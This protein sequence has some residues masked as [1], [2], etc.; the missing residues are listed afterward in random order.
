MVSMGKESKI[1][2]LEKEISY[3]KDYLLI[4][5]YRYTNLY[6]VDFDIQGELLGYKIP[7]FILQ[8]IVENAIVHG[9]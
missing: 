6:Q 9:V 5:S 1:I 8:P 2:P 3:V 4:Q 7:K